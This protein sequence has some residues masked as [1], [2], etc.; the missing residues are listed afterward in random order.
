MLAIFMLPC[1]AVLYV[2]A[3]VMIDASHLLSY[4]F[5]RYAMWLVAGMASWIF[6]A[7]YWT[8]LWRASVTWTPTRLHRTSVASVGS[9]IIGIAAG[10]VM[11]LVDDDFGVWV[12]SVVAP[13]VWLIL[14]TLLWRESADERAV[15]A[16]GKSALT[17]PTCGYN[18]TGLQS[19]R[20]PECGTQFSL[21]ELISR[22]KAF[23]EP[24]LT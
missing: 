3:F 18:L 12:G 24:D 8:L 19:T 15:R 17:C 2:I 20:C 11:G 9:I 23:S 14:T 7:V 13:L 1:A 16:S 4:P 6:I 5:R 10:A 22:Q 21:D